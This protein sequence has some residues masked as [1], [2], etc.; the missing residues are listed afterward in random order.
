MTNSNKSL[1]YFDFCV[2]KELTKT[3]M[4]KGFV[5][6]TT[7]SLLL[8]SHLPK[9][10]YSNIWNKLIIARRYH[11]S[12]TPKKKQVLNQKAIWNKAKRYNCSKLFY[13]YQVKTLLHF[14]F[15][16]DEISLKKCVWYKINSMLTYSFK[17]VAFFLIVS[18]FTGILTFLEGV[19]G[20]RRQQPN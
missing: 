19:R 10:N 8:L 7:S 12:S 5:F 13:I 4:L 1:I 11:H 20:G 15:C 3:E 6:M 2:S 18:I 9:V 17:K 14:T 16:Y